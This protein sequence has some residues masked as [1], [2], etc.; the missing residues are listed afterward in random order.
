MSKDEYTKSLADCILFTREQ[1]ASFLNFSVSW[2]DKFRKCGKLK[3]VYVT[4]V[5]G[6]TRPKPMFHRDELERF[7]KSLPTEI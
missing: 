5:P 3:A 6:A 7:A 1:A 2:I 4:S